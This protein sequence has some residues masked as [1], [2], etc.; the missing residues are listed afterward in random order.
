MHTVKQVNSIDL[1]H[2]S[3]SDLQ[4]EARLADRLG[5]DYECYIAVVENSP[6]NVQ[7]FWLS[8]ANRAGIAWGAD[9]VWTDADSPEDALERFLGIGGKEIIN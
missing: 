8:G 9:A 1:A 3:A 7:M 2:L 4:E 6:E 5:N